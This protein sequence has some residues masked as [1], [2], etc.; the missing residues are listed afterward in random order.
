M[1]I[2]FLL[3]LCALGGCATGMGSSLRMATGVTAQTTCNAAFVSGLDAG[4]VAHDELHGEP[5]MALIDWAMKTT[6]DRQAKGVRVSVFGGY[7]AR[8]FFR[9]G[10]GCTLGVGDT[11]P[12]ALS[13]APIM[14]ASSPDMAGPAPV[15]A[16][17]PQIAAAIDAAFAEPERGGRRGTHAIV[18]V[19]R[20]RVIG[21]RYAPGIGVR[22]PLNSHSLAKSVVS[23]L[24]GILARDGRMALNETV[25]LSA[26][27]E[28]RSA[29]RRT[30]IAALL[31]MNDGFGFDEGTGENVA[32]QIWFL[33]ADTAAAAADSLARSPRRGQWGY[34]NRCY[35]IL[36]RRIGE[37]VG[38]GPQG[39][40]DFAAREL[41]GPLGMSDTILEF[42]Q[43]GTMMGANALF[44][45]ARDFARFGLLYA[46]RGSVGG[47]RVLPD[48]WVRLS[49]EPSA[50][51]G[52]GAGF[53]TNTMHGRMPTWPIDWGLPGAPADAYF[54]KGYLGQ[55]IVIVPS[56]DLVIVRMGQSH[57]RR[58]E[59]DAV[60]R[61]T[62]DIVRAIDGGHAGQRAAP[63]VG[64]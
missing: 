17:D 52:Y 27:V 23:A 42:D 47:R 64:V 55:Y 54:A 39:V 58:M 5:G 46:G 63:P 19:S 37:I 2:W 60:G 18:V 30:T 44:A 29:A 57:R 14:V 28:P 32:G 38:G 9:E 12:T 48:E 45:S 51:T 61:L 33:R 35:M 62:A 24:I 16:R 56:R 43:A 4:R 20:G 22:T 36:S 53:W 3:T 13:A 11:I 1:R 50:G 41:F 6:I 25:T 21:E 34:C 26:T 7:S 40:R 10:R 49:S 8:A 59:L 31:R 15:A